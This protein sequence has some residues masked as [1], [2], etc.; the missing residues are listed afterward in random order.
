MK[1]SFFGIDQTILGP[2]LFVLALV[3]SVKA[4]FFFWP[5]FVE[6]FNSVSDSMSARR[7]QRMQG[8]PGPKPE[9][10]LAREYD[11]ERFFVE[12]RTQKNRKWLAV[13]SNG[14][15]YNARYF[16]GEGEGTIVFFPDEEA[17]SEFIHDQLKQWNEKYM[18][19]LA[20]AH[21]LKA[22]RTN[23]VFK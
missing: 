14:E 8:H 1:F 19:W 12:R 11:G 23:R 6:A 20:G 17:V 5:L 7:A 10:Q 22:I 4:L 2:V 18:N 3:I 13:K 9:Y 16:V 21:T 15:R